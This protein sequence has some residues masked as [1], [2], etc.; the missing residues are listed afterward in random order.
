MASQVN[1]EWETFTQRIKNSLAYAESQTTKL[2]K[3]ESRLQIITLISS[4]AATLVAGITAAQGPL[5]GNG[6][7]GWQLA[8]IIAAVFAFIG[9]VCTGLN[10]QLR[11]NDR[12]TESV[13]CVGRLKS[14]DVAVT[15]GSRNRDEIKKD[16]EETARTFP[17]LVK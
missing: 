6:E 5:V 11:I 16:Y 1:P 13:Q 8:C 7:Q 4:A 10:Q 12:L 15:T 17:E 3:T 14:L 2:R 9:T